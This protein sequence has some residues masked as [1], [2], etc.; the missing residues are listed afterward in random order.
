MDFGKR[1]AGLRRIGSLASCVCRAVEREEATSGGPH[2][3]A[4]GLCPSVAVSGKAW[5]GGGHWGANAVLWERDGE[6]E[7]E[8]GAE[9]PLQEE[10]RA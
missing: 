10:R 5:G 7:Q 2:V 8:S 4:L 6:C 1:R 3:P 9:N